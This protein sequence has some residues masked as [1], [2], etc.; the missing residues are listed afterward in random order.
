MEYKNHEELGENIGRVEWE[1]E[2]RKAF[3][4]LLRPEDRT[5]RE[6]AAIEEDLVHELLHIV[7]QG[8]KSYKKY[9][10]QHERS[11]NQVTGALVKRY[12]RKVL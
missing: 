12:R 1:P 10:P 4:Y 7:F 3:I 8:H 9:N 2:Y 11:I 6:M 5:E